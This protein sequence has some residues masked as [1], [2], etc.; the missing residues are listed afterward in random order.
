M[1]CVGAIVNGC[2]PW[3]SDF[4]SFR[5]M[6]KFIFYQSWGTETGCLRLLLLLNLLRRSKLGSSP[7]PGAQ[8]MGGG[9]SSL[10]FGWWFSSDDFLLMAGRC[11]VYK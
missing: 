3:V 10:R 6:V 9:R 4:M 5:V 2:V 8:Q 1:I 7:R 11:L